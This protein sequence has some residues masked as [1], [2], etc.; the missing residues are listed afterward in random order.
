MKYVYFILCSVL[1]QLRKSCKLCLVH[2]IK[3]PFE[4]Q[5]P[6]QFEP[7]RNT[8]LFDKLYNTKGVKPKQ[9]KVKCSWKRMYWQ[10]S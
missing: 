3:K 7:E 4:I 1:A 6:S 5:E 10:Y 8:V 2:S 9:F